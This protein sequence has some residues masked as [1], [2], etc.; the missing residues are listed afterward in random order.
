MRKAAWFTDSKLPVEFNSVPYTG[1]FSVFIKF[2]GNPA[3]TTSLLNGSNA[4][5]PLKIGEMYLI[6]AE[7][8]LEGGDATKAA[9]YLNMLQ[10]KRGTARTAAT[11]ETVKNEW[12]KETIGD[13]LRMSCL[14]RWGDGYTA[15]TPQAAALEAAIL[16]TTGDYYGT[17]SMKADDRAFCWPIPAYELKVNEN[18]VPQQNPGYSAEE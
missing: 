12:F 10:G 11:W 13:G 4:P 7:A 2:E 18:L 5:K 8:A 16:Q 3:L 9:E 6:A 15:R 14:K 1:L 17:R